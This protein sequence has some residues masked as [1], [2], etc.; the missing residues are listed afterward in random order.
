ME[1]SWPES[2][3]AGSLQGQEE[4][5]GQ[6]STITAG[7][8]LEARARIENHEGAP[9]NYSLRLLFGNSTI[10]VKGLHL[11]DNESWDSMLGFVLEGSPDGRSSLSSSSR[12]Q[13][14]RGLTSP[15]TS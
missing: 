11:A 7:R 12:I 15:S 6:Y 3:I 14:A 8:E 9:A 2:E 10:F 13:R 1:V 4:R 5:D